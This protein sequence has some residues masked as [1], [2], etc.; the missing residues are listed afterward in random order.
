MGAEFR[1]YRVA[2]SG[3]LVLNNLAVSNGATPND[4]GALLS[5]PPGTVVPTTESNCMRCRLCKS[6]YIPFFKE[7]WGEV[8]SRVTFSRSA[9]STP[10]MVPQTISK[11]SL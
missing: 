8:A 10:G 1:I 5:S 3:T 9:S 11:P 6:P 7:D 2:G 4:G